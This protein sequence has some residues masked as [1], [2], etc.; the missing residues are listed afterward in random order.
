MSKYEP[1]TYWQERLSRDFSLVGVGRL[2]IGIGYNQWLY[3]A[4]LGELTKLLK[5]NQINAQGK[6]VL[7]I[8]VGNGF[9]V[10]YWKRKGAQSVTGIDITEKSVSTLST[11]YPEYQFL[12]ADISAKELALEGTFDIITAFDV[13]F[14]VV[15]E[16]KFEQAI[17]NIRRLSHPQTKVL[18]M[19][20]FLKN[21]LPAS[22]HQN[23]RTL[24]RYQG[25]LKEE[26][27]EMVEL[28]PIFY[29]M[30]A[31]IDMAAV[32][33]KVFRRLLP[34]VWALILKGLNLSKRLPLFRRGTDFLIGHTLGFL[35][36][37]IDGIILKYSQDGPSEK[38]LFA[39]IKE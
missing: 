27:I 29:F 3:K 20:S 25:V 33:S 32:K 9:Y 1:A 19:D 23:Y 26:G 16:D 17:R 7:D 15:D 24:T 12:K 8:G 2:D 34:Y 37:F 22:F 13:L 6:R 39:K 36:Y 10:D 11:K 4:R 35:F 14:H 28:V 30:T 18:I 31:P 5:K 38:L 21:P